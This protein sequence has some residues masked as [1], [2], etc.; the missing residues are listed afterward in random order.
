[1][2]LHDG[3]TES[4]SQSHSPAGIAFFPAAASVEHLKNRLFFRIRD[5]VSVVCDL[6]HRLSIF[7]KGPYLNLRSLRRVFD[8]IINQVHEYLHDQSHIYFRHQQGIFY[9]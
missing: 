8:S 2:R 7:R 5:T 9:F 3:F 1:M 6:H 4:E